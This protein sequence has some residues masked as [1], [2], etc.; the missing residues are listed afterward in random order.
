MLLVKILPENTVK[1]FGWQLLVNDNVQRIISNA[2]F[3]LKL[4]IFIADEIDSC[5]HTGSFQHHKPVR[6]FDPAGFSCFVITFRAAGLDQAG[7]CA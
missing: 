3:V 7:R 5:F 1:Q 6:S 2:D 4:A